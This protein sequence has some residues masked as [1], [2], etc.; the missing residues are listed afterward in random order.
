MCPPRGEQGQARGCLSWRLYYG[1]RGRFSIPLD[2]DHGVVVDCSS[3][4]HSRRWS[5]TWLSSRRMICWM[6]TP[7]VADN[8]Y[9]FVTSW[10]CASLGVSAGSCFGDCYRVDFAPIHTAISWSHLRSC[11]F[12]IL[13]SV[14]L[15]AGGRAAETLCDDVA[16]MTDTQPN[17]E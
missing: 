6:C 1:L 7:S 5:H 12:D 9:T 16:G 2:I 8:L 15:G 13:T 4:S 11:I 10:A 17:P 3:G 14:R